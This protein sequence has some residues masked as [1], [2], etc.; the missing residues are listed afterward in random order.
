M[1]YISFAF[2]KQYKAGLQA[3]T[4]KGYDLRPDAISIQAAKLSTRIASDVS[5]FA[6]S[7]LHL[8]F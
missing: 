7:L 6:F 2:K 8:P 4:K 1:Q 3:L 5:T